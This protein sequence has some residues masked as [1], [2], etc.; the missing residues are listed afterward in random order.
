[1]PTLTINDKSVVVSAGRTVYEGAAA[2]GIV[3]PTL[4]HHPDLAPVGSCRLCLVE[5]EGETLHP[6]CTLPANEGM[7][8]RTESPA[9]TAH[10]RR[11]LEML[12]RHFRVSG[13]SW[14]EQD[15]E[16]LHWVR[17]YGAQPQ[18]SGW[19]LAPGSTP[20]R[21]DRGLA[22][23]RSLDDPQPRFAVDSDPNPFIRV[24]L[25]QCIL[26]TRCVRACNEVQGR[27]VWHLAQRGEQS[28]IVAG[29][30]TTLLEARCESCGACEAYC[31][32]GALTDRFATGA[33]PPERQVRLLRCRLSI[34]LEHQSGPRH[35]CNVHT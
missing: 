23:A 24:D 28:H 26:C 9:L 33:A 10:R 22:P 14:A 1:M 4:C 20:P 18:V 27:F 31:P 35:A 29:T 2:A 21:T 12:L 25:N 34:R 32:T 6:A 19:A 3:I 13:G 8:V 17:H 15:N 7:V 30:G 16:F 11:T 5:V